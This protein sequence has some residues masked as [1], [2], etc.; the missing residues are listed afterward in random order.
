VRQFLCGNR[1]KQGKM[2]DCSGQLEQQLTDIGHPEKRPNS[3][4]NPEAGARMSMYTS[5]V[6]GLR[7]STRSGD[8]KRLVESMGQMD[9]IVREVRT[10]SRE[11]YV[12]AAKVK[13][14]RAITGLSQ[15]KFAKLLHVDVGGLRNW[16]QG[17]HQR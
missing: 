7:K 13:Q 1:G 14:I 16:E 17:R 11:F 9:E 8:I 3:T 10:P 15:P 12:D 5:L 4:D 2:L 6:Y